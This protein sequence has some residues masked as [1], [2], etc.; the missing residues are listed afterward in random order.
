MCE[1]TYRIPAINFPR[2]ESEIEKLNKRAAKLNTEPVV[3]TTLETVV[4]KKRNDVIGFDYE[5]TYYVCTVTGAAPKL[6]GWTLVAVIDPVAAGEN[7]VREVPGQIC[8]VNFRTTNM[9]CD[10][11]GVMRRRNAIFVLKHEDGEHKQVGRNCIADFLG[12]DHPESLLSRA[13]YMFSFDKLIGEATEE[14]WGCGHG[15]VLVPTTEFTAVAAIVIRR[16]GWLPISK[17][18]EF[19]Q[20]TANIVWDICTRPHDRHIR[21]LIVKEKIHAEERDVTQAVDAVTWAAALDPANESSTYL[22]DL[23][24]CCRQNYVD[25]RRRGFV[26]SV[27][28]AHQRVLNELQMKNSPTN[29]SKHVGEIDKRQVFPDLLILSLVPYMS[30]IYNKTLV[31]FHDP[32]GNVIIWRASGK[33]EWLK[34]GDKFTVKATVKKH[35]DYQGVNQTEVSRV[36][37]VVLDSSES[38][39]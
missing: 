14:C 8:P 36:E 12:H 29:V 2:L 26:A 11:C 23:G 24:V 33:P 25:H 5:E 19:E 28:Q 34:L 20:P 18:G 30:G 22:H 37:P 9:H 16:L 7:M 32:D 3:L 6:A 31:T 21:E 4:E 27:I 39:Q 10:H 35:G 15:P 17:A 38:S 1:R 13:E